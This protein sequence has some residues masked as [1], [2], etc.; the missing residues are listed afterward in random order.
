MAKV[1]C[2]CEHE[3]A[4]FGGSN[5]HIRTIVAEKV[6][7]F[8]DLVRDPHQLQRSEEHRIAVSPSQ[9]NGA[10][11]AHMGVSREAPK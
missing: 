8:E 2:S 11:E 10:T 9:P 6:W 4:V 5:S 7:A 1:G 3:S